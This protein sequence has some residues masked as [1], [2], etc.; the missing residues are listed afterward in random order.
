[1]KKSSGR[2]RA[3]MDS[4]GRLALAEWIARGNKQTTLAKILDCSQPLVAQ[5]LDGT[6]R[7]NS[8]DREAMER[9]GICE[10]DAW[11]TAEER[12]RLD[13]IAAKAV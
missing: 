7:P 2:R 5:W 11:L 10:A 13:D 1:M 3:V 12:V 4:R 8:A 9:L 6:V